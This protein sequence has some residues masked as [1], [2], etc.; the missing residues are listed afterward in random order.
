MS[1]QTLLQRTNG[2]DT[3]KDSNLNLRV[4]F[5][6]LLA[7]DN[8][9]F[10]D[11]DLFFGNSLFT[12]RL[13]RRTVWASSGDLWVEFPW[14]VICG[15][16]CSVARM[17]TWFLFLLV[18]GAFFLPLQ[19]PR[20]TLYPTATITRVNFLHFAIPIFCQ[21]LDE[22]NYRDSTVYNSSLPPSKSNCRFDK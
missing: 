16:E 11:G 19:L 14:P 20:L 12:W 5:S 10:N 18:V 15:V 8:C 1:D 22:T 4:L 6:V 21:P 17:N 13:V 3:L 9:W 2:S 7:T